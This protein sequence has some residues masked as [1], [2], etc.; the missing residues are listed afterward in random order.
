[1]YVLRKSRWV[2]SC[3]SCVYVFRDLVFDYVMAVQVLMSMPR[4]HCECS[5]MSV[6]V[7]C[8]CVCL[9][10]MIVYDCNKKSM[11]VCVCFLCMCVSEQRL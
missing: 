3:V 10:E 4:I 2:Y 9:R 5:F 8:V 11:G 1:M 6:T 7:V